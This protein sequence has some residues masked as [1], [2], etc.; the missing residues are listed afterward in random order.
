MP[1]GVGA[2]AIDLESSGALVEGPLERV[3]PLPGTGPR[4]R[5][6]WDVSII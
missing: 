6:L 1:F 5:A 2:G 3:L 4:K